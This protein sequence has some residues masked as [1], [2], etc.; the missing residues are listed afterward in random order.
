MLT[1]FYGV[2]WAPNTSQT[3]VKEI[4][5]SKNL[6]RKHSTFSAAITDLSYNHYFTI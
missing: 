4:T 1:F 3:E 2:P 5:S 6:N